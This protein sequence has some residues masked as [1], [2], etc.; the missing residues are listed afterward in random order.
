VDDLVHEAEDRPAAYVPC[1]VR[2]L[3]A[4]GVEE[5]DPRLGDR[6]A[7]TD[8]CGHE[9]PANAGFERT[10]SIV[11]TN[12]VRVSRVAG[13]LITA[14]ADS[15]CGAGPESMVG[16]LERGLE[17]RVLPS[18]G[19]DSIPRRPSIIIVN[20]RHDRKV[21]TALVERLL[22]VALCRPLAPGGMMRRR[23]QRHGAAERRG[24]YARRSR[25]LVVGYGFVRRGADRR[26]ASRARPK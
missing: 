21:P 19:G 18:S 24:R 10:R 9:T 26:C 17:R 16:V 5:L 2:V 15:Q 13:E 7:E 22:G 20:P 6:L 12:A 3:P 25:V 14:S 4:H 8:G 1:K 11:S 23:A